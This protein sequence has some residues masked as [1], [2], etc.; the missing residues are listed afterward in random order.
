MITGSVE[1]QEYLRTL[2]NSYNPPNILIRIPVDE[3]VYKTEHSDNLSL[4]CLGHSKR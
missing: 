1:Y 3:P 2:A 4:V